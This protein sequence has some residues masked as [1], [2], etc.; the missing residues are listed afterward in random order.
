MN[1]GDWHRH[2]SIGSTKTLSDYLLSSFTRQNVRCWLIE[3]FKCLCSLSLILEMFEKPNICKAI[4]SSW[5]LEV[6]NSNNAW[7]GQ[8][9]SVCHILHG[10]LRRIS[11]FLQLLDRFHNF[12]S[13]RFQKATQWF[14][15]F[16]L[17]SDKVSDWSKQLYSIYT[18]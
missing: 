16:Q 15:N 8:L 11:W 13:T 6:L 14:Y 3:E 2:R 1:I 4:D 17:I 18:A 12:I 10:F 9:L 7:F 5:R